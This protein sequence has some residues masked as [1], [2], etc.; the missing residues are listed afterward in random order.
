MK[1]FLF[2]SLL[3]MK[4]GKAGANTWFATTEQG[5]HVGWQIPAEGNPFFA[6]QPPWPRAIRSAL[7]EKKTTT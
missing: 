2:N 3:D 7:T 4:K 5:G 6:C 1:S